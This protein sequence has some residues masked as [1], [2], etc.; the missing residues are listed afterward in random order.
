VSSDSEHRTSTRVIKQHRVVER[1]PLAAVSR[2]RRALGTAGVY[3]IGYGNVGSSIYYALG[4]VAAYAW[5][6][7]P[8]TRESRP[9]GR[10]E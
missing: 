4:I 3:A 5:G 7:T 1:A 9:D 6:A 10:T 2:L 8:P